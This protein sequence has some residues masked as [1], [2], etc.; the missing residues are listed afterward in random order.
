MN[1]KTKKIELS[2][3]YPLEP[4]SMAR[5]DRLTNLGYDIKLTTQ[6]EKL[7]SV[8]ESF[9]DD[10]EE[11]EVLSA[12]KIGTEDCIGKKDIRELAKKYFNVESN[13]Y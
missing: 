10:M 1:R 5:L 4:L 3:R 8:E 13:K 9:L 7:L 11:L 2:F 6:A 12:V